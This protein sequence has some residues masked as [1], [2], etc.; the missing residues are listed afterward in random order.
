M[1]NI[2]NAII[3][4]NLLFDGTGSELVIANVGIVD[5]RI[6]PPNANV[7]DQASRVV[8]TDSWAHAK[9]TGHHE[10]PLTQLKQRV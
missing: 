4:N 9:K 3:K 7:N 2:Y 5:G 6:A 8:D 1:A 10:S